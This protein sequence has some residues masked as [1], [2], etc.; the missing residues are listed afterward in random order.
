[1]LK[2]NKPEEIKYRTKKRTEAMSRLTL[3]EVDRY[4]LVPRAW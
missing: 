2:R 1:M 4:K 3:S